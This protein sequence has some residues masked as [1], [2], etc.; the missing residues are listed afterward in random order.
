MKIVRDM[1]QRLQDQNTKSVVVNIVGSFGVK[2][3]SMFIGLFTTP[4]YIR[5]FNNNEVL[6]IWFTLLSVLAWI[7]NCDMGIGNGLR[8]KLVVAMNSTECDEGKKYVSS[9]Y[10]FSG[11]VASGVIIA[12][13]V[14]SY[15][16]N[17][18]EVFNISTDI[19]SKEVLK[20]AV[21]V[22]LLGVCLQLILRLITSVLYAVQKAFIPGLLNL[23]TNIIMLLY[24]ILTVKMGINGDIIALAWAYLVAVNIPLLITTFWVFGFTYKNLAPSFKYYNKTY[25]LATLKIGGTFLWIQ[26]MAMV[27]NSTNSYLVTVFIGNAAVVEF[28]IYVKIFSLL[29]TLVI[30]GATPIWSA[31]TKALVEENYKWLYALFKKFSA[32]SLMAVIAEFLLIVPLQFIFDVWLGEKTIPVN[33]V[34]ATLFAVYGAITIWS[35]TITCF[36][37]GLGE[38]KLQSIFLTFGALI[39]ILLTY[40][41]VKMTGSYISVLL[42]NVIAFIPYLSVQTVWLVCFLKRK[43]KET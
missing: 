12:V 39:D 13:V 29:G 41:F 32:I 17:W 27:L 38:L 40:V 9:A 22:L 30:L 26:L 7:L 15:F 19:L 36:V 14:L 33:Y 43:V 20:E 6:G 1:Q 2:G 10:L 37:N 16:V 24:A 31:T 4:M 8:N 11:I 3:L 28:N 34:Y 5:Y 42:A 21:I 23:I 35:S 18:N 25:A